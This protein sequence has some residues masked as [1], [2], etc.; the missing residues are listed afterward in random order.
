[1]SI[2]PIIKL[3]VYFY[4]RTDQAGGSAKLGVERGR[5]F[6]N[7]SGPPSQIRSA[8]LNSVIAKLVTTPPQKV[9]TSYLT[10]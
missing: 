8:S 4:L 3:G 5:E 10:D 7:P 6:N 1:M 2:L 9:E